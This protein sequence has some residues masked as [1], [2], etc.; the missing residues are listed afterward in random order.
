MKKGMSLSSPMY[1][2]SLCL[3][4]D[5]QCSP[6][7]YYYLKYLLRSPSKALPIAFPSGGRGTALGGG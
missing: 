5:E 7:Q 2:K 6:L 3:L 4:A 1:S